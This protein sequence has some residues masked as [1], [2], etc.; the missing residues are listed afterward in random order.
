MILAIAFLLCQM[1]TAFLEA[2]AQQLVHVMSSW[3]QHADILKLIIAA[4]ITVI[5]AAATTGY[6]RLNSSSQYSSSS[7]YHIYSSSS[8]SA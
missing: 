2:V 3:S 4:I 6:C 7:S 8:S 5:D 1:R